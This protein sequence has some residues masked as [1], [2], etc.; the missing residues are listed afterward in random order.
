MI[1]M[2]RSILFLSLLA[3]IAVLP[4]AHL[5]YAHKWNEGQPQ[6]YSKLLT[7]KEWRTLTH[8]EKAEWVGAIKVRPPASP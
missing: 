2:G 8:I 5:S 3:V 6:K 4:R 7:R 1:A